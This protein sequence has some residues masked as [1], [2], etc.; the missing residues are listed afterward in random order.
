MR[1]LIRVVGV[2]LIVSFL[3]ACGATKEEKVQK[4]LE[5]A[6]EKEDV[7]DEEQKEIAKL[8]KEEGEI[9][10]KI[11][12][13]TDDEL[14][15]IDKLAKTA[16]ANIDKRSEKIGLEQDSMS[17]AKKEFKKAKSHIAD[18][19]DEDVKKKANAMY[20]TMEER[21]GIH[22]EI[23][24]TY[25]ATLEKEK[26]FYQEIPKKDG[27]EEDIVDILKELN[28]NYEEL[29]TKTEAFNEKTKK[30]NE[31]KATYYKAADLDVEY[32]KEKN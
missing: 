27:S 32:A 28:K 2:I 3:A 22:N 17:A 7:Y 8:E 26:E 10:S 21:Y 16:I 11:V 23:I 9:F 1:N 25:E 15:E 19:E 6:F 14:D 31:D 24:K 13:M 4:A 18:I 12:D 29:V 20:K 5:T 30:Y